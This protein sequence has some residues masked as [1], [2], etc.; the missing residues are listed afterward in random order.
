MT[1]FDIRATTRLIAVAGVLGLG[2]LL[3]VAHG[4]PSHAGSTGGT[5]LRQVWGEP[6]LMGVW[7]AAK[8]DA[9]SGQDQSDLAKLEALYRPGARKSVSP[10]D[11]PA[12]H[13]VPSAFPRAATYGWPIQIVQS[14]GWVYIYSEAFATYRTI[15]TNGSHLSPN[16]LT[17]L[18]LGDSAGNW[19]GDKLVVDVTSFNGQSWLASSEDKPTKSSLGVWPTSDALHVVEQWRRVDENT[20]EYQARV[21]DPKMLTAAWE[22]PKV[23]FTK[24]PSSKIYEVKCL[25][26]DPEPGVKVSDPALYLK[27]FGR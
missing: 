2:T 13:C 24:Q 6:N 20:L 23:R 25:L 12:L 22:T 18:Y 9:R 27:Q 26:G 19:Q 7:E 10:Q 15:P 4:A 17:P 11:D 3:A 16:Y 14:P 8:L 1:K 5:E 21:E